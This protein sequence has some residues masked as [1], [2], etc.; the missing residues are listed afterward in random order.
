MEAKKDYRLLKVLG[1]GAAALTLFAFKKKSDYSKVIEQMT[2]FIRSI[3]NL[4]MKNAK[5][6]VDFDLEF[7]NPT[8]FDFD[9]FTAGMIKLK[10]INLFHTAAGKTT[11]IGTALSDLTS[12]SL[13]AKSNFTVSNITI[14][15]LLLNVA[16]QFLNEGLDTNINNYHVTI[17]I[18]ALGK[19]WVV[20]P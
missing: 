19:I 12:F 6:Y 15:L 3:R 4:R 17:E 16:N 14:E 13:P 10:R 11:K 1:V 8:E 9:V 2:F 20:E 5:I 7:F 18:E